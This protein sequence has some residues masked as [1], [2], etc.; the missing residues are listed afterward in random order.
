M[1]ILFLNS[2][3]GVRSTG[4][5]IAQ[6]CRELTQQGH[7]CVVAYGREAVPDGSAR[8][9]RIGSE[10]DQNVHGMYSRL[11]D[12]HGLGSA[13][14]TKTF[15]SEAD[16]EHFD[17]VWMHNI[18]GYY[19]HYPLLFQW[20]KQHSELR[21]NWTLHDCWAFTGHCAYFTMAHCEKWKTGCGRCEQ[22]HTYPKA[23][24]LDGS[25]RNYLRKQQAFSGVKNLTLIT[26]SQWL[27][28]MTRDSFLREYPVRV[29]RNE[30][31]RTVFRPTPSDF[32]ERNGLT[33]K[34]IVLGVAVGWEETKGIQDIIELRALLDVRYTI[35]LVGDLTGKQK[36][37]PQGILHISRTKDQKELAAIYTAADVLVNP[38]HQDNYPTVNLE[39]AACGT[40]VV[41]YR[42]GGSPESVPPENAF[43]ENDV[44]GMARRIEEICVA[45]VWR[46]KQIE[47][48]NESPK[49]N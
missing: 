19:L 34:R 11:L 4:K 32:R 14:A 41:T 39:A 28:D 25:R 44:A 42:V 36:T 5:L 31:D 20:L 1:K 3:Y 33:D 48:S 6:Q 45:S 9:I 16:K 46:A 22:L 26:P 18:H 43:E 15:L 37:L 17:L 10:L 38:T 49:G 24:L 35:V 7:S 13:R 21:V 23:L 30:I 27:A 47:V 12:A 2:V 29:I 40:P 8:L